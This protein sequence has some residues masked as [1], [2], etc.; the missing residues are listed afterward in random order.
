MVSTVPERTTV[1]CVA[2]RRFKRL[3]ALRK[4]RTATTMAIAPNTV[5]EISNPLLDFTSRLRSE[6][7]I[8]V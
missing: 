6:F 1:F 2:L 7:G 5:F 3:K 4:V 8:V